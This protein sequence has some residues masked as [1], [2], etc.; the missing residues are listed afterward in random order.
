MNRA[1]CHLFP[2]GTYHVA[3]DFMLCRTLE[4]PAILGTDF[5]DHFF[6]AIRSR[7]RTVELDEGSYIPFVK[8][9]L[10]SVSDP[11]LTRLHQYPDNTGKFAR[12]DSAIK[13][14]QW[15]LVPLH[16]QYL[17]R[18]ASQRHGLIILQPSSWLYREHQLSCANRV[19]LGEAGIPFR[20]LIPNFSG[21]PTRVKRNKK[22]CG[23]TLIPN[24]NGYHLSPTGENSNYI[25]RVRR[26]VDPAATPRIC[27]QEARKHANNVSCRDAEVLSAPD[28]SSHRDVFNTPI[29]TDPTPRDAEVLPAPTTSSHREVLNTLIASLPPPGDERYRRHPPNH[30]IGRL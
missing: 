7:I 29:A 20:V 27:T 3:L 2:L 23:R 13:A 14:A 26:T 5:F 21:T 19:G 11:S 18:V 4:A 24:I 1:L 15:I 10:G 28:T 9:P 17:L 22:G 30:R 25:P 8:R 6:Q 16:S 12:L